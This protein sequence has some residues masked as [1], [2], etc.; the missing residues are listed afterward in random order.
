[1]HVSA[2]GIV[3]DQSTAASQGRR[4]W[5]TVTKGV[6]ISGESLHGTK[7]YGITVLHCAALEG[8]STNVSHTDYSPIFVPRMQEGGRMA[9]G[10][11]VRGP[12]SMWEEPYEP[13]WASL[14][15][16]LAMEL[17]INLADKSRISPDIGG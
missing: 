15:P 3:R 7:E 5:P 4:H 11:C 6:D 10:W 12:L 13:K 1:M 16:N 14:S 17:Q 8:T 9:R 2:C